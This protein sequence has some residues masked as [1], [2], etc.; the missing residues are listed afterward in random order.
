M[1]TALKNSSSVPDDALF[2]GE[3]NLFHI[4]PMKIS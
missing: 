4:K 3:P 2:V 1:P